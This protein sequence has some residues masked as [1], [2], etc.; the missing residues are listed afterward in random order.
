MIV[1]ILNLCRLPYFYFYVKSDTQFEKI[2]TSQRAITLG[3][4]FSPIILAIYPSTLDT[5][6]CHGVSL[7]SHQLSLRQREVTKLFS[8]STQ[9]S[10]KIYPPHNVKMATIVG[11][12]TFIS[13]INTTSESLNTRNIFIFQHFSCMSN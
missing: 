8:C 12:L 3:K 4:T 5:E 10:M 11:I 9:L 1:L 2:K 6:G 13:M 7:K